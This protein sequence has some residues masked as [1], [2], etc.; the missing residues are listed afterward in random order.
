MS[1]A[2]P[3]TRRVKRVFISIVSSFQSECAYPIRPFWIRVLNSNQRAQNR[4]AITFDILASP[5]PG[6]KLRK[7]GKGPAADDDEAQ[8]RFEYL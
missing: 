6:M 7:A 5:G 4:V 1:E 3:R 8:K 2:S